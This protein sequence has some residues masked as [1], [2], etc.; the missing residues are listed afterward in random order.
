MAKALSSSARTSL[1]IV[2][3]KSS[4]Y[5]QIA[6]KGSGVTAQMI[7]PPYD[8]HQA[9]GDK[10]TGLSSCFFTRVC[11]MMC[12]AHVSDFLDNSPRPH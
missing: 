5:K 4:Y 12:T 6:Q 3:L 7:R 1:S 11:L 2:R 8:K 10:F 9:L